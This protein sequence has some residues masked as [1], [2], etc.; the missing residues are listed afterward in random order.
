ML[1]A[2]TQGAGRWEE[3]GHVPYSNLSTKDLVRKKPAR[4]ILPLSIGQ[5]ANLVTP[6]QLASLYATIANGGTVWKPTLLKKIISPFG[7]LVEK[8]GHEKIKD[9][10]LVSEANFKRMQKLL[11]I[12]NEDIW[13][14]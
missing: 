12:L 11:E 8:G 3:D 2:Q 5:G 6:V 10:G 4:D 7:E 13:E 14:K 9:V 1:T